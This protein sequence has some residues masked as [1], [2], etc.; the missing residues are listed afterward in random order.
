MVLLALVHVLVDCRRH[1]GVELLAAQTVSAA[2]HFR[3]DL[4]LVKRG[5]D[6]EIERLAERA[7]FLGAIQDGDLLGGLGESGDELFRGEGAVQSDFD[8]AHLLA[9]GV[10]IIDGLFHGFRAAAHQDDD[11]VGVLRAVV[12]HQVILS[13]RDARHFVHHVLDDAG[14]RL[15]V[16]VGGFAVLEIDVG[17]LRRARL[18]RMLG[19]EGTR[20]ETVDVVKVHEAL[21]LVVVDDVDLAHFVRGPESVKEVD[22]GDGGFQRGK[23]RHEAQVHDFLHGVGREHRKA[24]LTARHDVRMVAEN[25]QRVRGKGACRNVE[26]AGEQFAR[27]LV[28]IRDHEQQA[29]AGGESC[30]H[31]ARGER[32][33]DGARSARFG[34]HLDDLQHVAQDVFPALPRPFVAVF[35]HGRGGRD[36]VDSRNVGERI[37]DVRRRGITVDCHLFHKDLHSV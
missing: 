32:T 21:Y 33:V 11:A 36:G 26:D 29:L 25:A 24:R 20:A 14:D 5:D 19:V 28:H 30:G 10:E 35:R 34:L 31:R 23:M 15:I 6:V 27:D 1:G 37:C 22:E 7:R 12:V 8:D 17:V 3:L 2:Q 18:M 4:E 9:L 16:L 13:A